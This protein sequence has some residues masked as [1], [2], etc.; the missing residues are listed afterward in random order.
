[1]ESHVF[2]VFDFMSLAKSLQHHFTPS[3]YL[4][5][6]NE[7]NHSKSAR[8]INEIILAEETDSDGNGNYISHFGL[9]T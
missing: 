2:A 9:Y 4:W 6:P 8:L 5:I 3:S 7:L 1:M